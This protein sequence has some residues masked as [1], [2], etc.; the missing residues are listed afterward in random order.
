MKSTSSVRGSTSAV[1]GLPFTVME[2]L[3]DM[4]LLLLVCVFARWPT[5]RVE[6]CGSSPS[7]CLTC[8]K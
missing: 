4:D 3:T 6:G 2:T 5:H 1:T 8:R 7:L